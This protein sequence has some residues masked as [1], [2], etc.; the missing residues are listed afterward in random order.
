[1][2]VRILS[3][4]HVGGLQALFFIPRRILRARAAPVS[5]QPP[6]HTA[7]TSVCHD[8]GCFARAEVTPFPDTSILRCDA[9][10]QTQPPR[11]RRRFRPA[12]ASITFNFSKIAK[13]SLP[14]TKKEWKI[15]PFGIFY[16]SHSHR[17][18]N[19]GRIFTCA[20][21]LP[22]KRSITA[23]DESLHKQQASRQSLPRKPDP[24]PP[25]HSTYTIFPEYNKR[26]GKVS[27][28]NRIP[29]RLRS[30]LSLYF[31]NIGGAS[32]KSNPKTAFSICLCP[33]LSLY[34][35]PSTAGNDG[36]HSRQPMDT[37]PQ[38][39]SWALTET[40]ET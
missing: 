6:Y 23:R 4:L 15:Y 28:E 1:M 35:Y 7:N 13:L 8:N 40:C 27:H 37:L 17:D 9:A 10:P 18:D 38:K 21:S 19:Y 11:C 24:D 2:K 25:L 33:R 16:Y 5:R 26:L 20:R 34:L 32:A 3:R 39:A 22:D 31:R 36:S 12:K 14:I 29:I 30:R